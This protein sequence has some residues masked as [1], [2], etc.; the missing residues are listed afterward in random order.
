MHF[1][2]DSRPIVCWEIDGIY[3]FFIVAGGI[4]YRKNPGGLRLASK[5]CFLS[6]W[7]HQVSGPNGPIKSTTKFLICFGKKLPSSIWEGIIAKK[8]VWCSGGMGWVIVCNKFT[9]KLCSIDWK[10]FSSLIQKAH[11]HG[12]H[13]LWSAQSVCPLPF[14]NQDNSIPGEQG[15]IKLTLVKCLQPMPCDQSKADN[16][17]HI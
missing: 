10:Q 6:G 15:A 16:A 11:L 1:D 17:R 3:V 8:L 13:W 12:A 14:G 9:R 7:F 5:K 4:N 2:V